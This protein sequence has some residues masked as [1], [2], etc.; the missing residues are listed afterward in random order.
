MNLPF[1]VEADMLEPL[2]AAAGQLLPD[3][4]TLFEV[5]S[6]SG[7]P[8]AVLVDIDHHALQDR[9]GAGPLDE[10]I[11]VRVM[12]SFA[13]RSNAPMSSADI[14]VEVEVSEAHLRRRVL[15]RMADLGHLI[16]DGR[17]WNSAYTYQTLARRLVTVEA[18]LRDWRKGLRQASRHSLVADQAWLLVD[19][20]YVMSASQ[21]VRSFEAFGV[22]LAALSTDGGLH[23]VVAPRSAQRSTSGRELLAERAVALHSAGLTSGPLP[24]VFGVYRVAST[25]ADPRLAGALA[26]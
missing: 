23:Q 7:I 22:G 8:D 6:T 10:L 12:L 13:Q 11:D 4:E 16:V 17:H 19:A 9:N 5:G 1:G 2:R 25:G 18:K 26:R 24:L 15:P 20:R 14:A 3:A 21:H